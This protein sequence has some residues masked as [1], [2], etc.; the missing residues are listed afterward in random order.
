MLPRQD[1]GLNIVVSCVT[2]VRFSGCSGLSYAMD[3]EDGSNVGAED[4]GT[5]LQCSHH[6][7]SVHANSDFY[8]KWRGLLSRN[9]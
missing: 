4:S 7:D 8:V 9:V 5:L 1:Y 2:A 3:F 6:N